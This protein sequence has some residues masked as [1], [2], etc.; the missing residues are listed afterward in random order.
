[1]SSRNK[2]SVIL[3]QIF[4]DYLAQRSRFRNSRGGLVILKKG[5]CLGSQELARFT[6]VIKGDLSSLDG[7]NIDMKPLQKGRTYMCQE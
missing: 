4:L 6:G 3:V 2:N 7:S 5:I 1:M